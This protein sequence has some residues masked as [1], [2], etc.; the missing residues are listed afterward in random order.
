MTSELGVWAGHIDLHRDEHVSQAELN[1]SLVATVDGIPGREIAVAEH[2]WTLDFQAKSPAK[3]ND[4]T[5]HW[6]D[7][8]DDSYPWLRPY[9]TDPWTIGTSDDQPVLYLNSGFEGLRLLLESQRPA[10]R[11][12]RDALAARI[13]VDMWNVLFDAAAHAIK[14]WPGGWRGSVLRRM[15]P[16]VF[17]DRSPED[18]LRELTNER[19]KDL[20][21]RILHAAMRQARV[22][23]SLG[24]FIRATQTTGQEEM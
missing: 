3:R 18:A 24:T 15:L 10:D 14:E 22:P 9:R 21:A 17:P 1:A 2:P 4:L 11:L 23:A 16:D 13:A 5:T 12:A 6:V 8:N 20:Q 19:P 7:F